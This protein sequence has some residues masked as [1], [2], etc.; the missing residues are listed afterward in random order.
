MTGRLWFA[1]LAGHL[2]WSLHLMVSYYLAARACAAETG[3]TGELWTLRHA[4][5]IAAAALTLAGAATSWSHPEGS[6]RRAG[7]RAAS[8][9]SQ[10]PGAD[11]ATG[12]PAGGRVAPERHFLARVLFPLNATFLCAILA[13]GATNLFLPP[14]A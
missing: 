4:A 8:L 9:G 6:R 12:A 2:A 10:A 13:T 11:T 5:T 3:D 7:S 1:L 14:C